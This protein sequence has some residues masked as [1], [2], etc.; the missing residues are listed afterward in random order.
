MKKIITI[1][2]FLFI[3]S[4]ITCLSAQENI[5]ALIKRCENISSVDMSYIINKDPETKKIQNNITT[6]T[7]KNDANLVKDFIAAFEKDKDNAYSVSGSVKNGVS[8]PSNYKFSNGKDNYISCTMAISEDN[9]SASIS[10]RESP[11]KPNN[12]SVFLNGEFFNGATWDVRQPDFDNFS[13]MIR[14]I[15]SSATKVIRERTG[16]IQ[17]NNSQ[18]KNKL[19][20]DVLQLDIAIE[21]LQLSGSGTGVHVEKRE[22]ISRQEP[23][24]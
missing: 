16:V 15:D 22:P 5:K 8:I 19:D 2:L 10:Y 17:M 18:E 4:F 11:N 9:T 21:C 3:S 7:I 20:Q 14:E 13:R 1:A 12:I 6:I 24:I 23:L